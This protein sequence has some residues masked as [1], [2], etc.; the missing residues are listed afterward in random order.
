MTANGFVGWVCSLL[1]NHIHLNSIDPLEML[2]NVPECLH[3]QDFCHLC[4][5]VEF[6][7]GNGEVSLSALK[8]TLLVLAALIEEWLRTVLFETEG[9]LVLDLVV[10]HVV[11]TCQEEVV[12]LWK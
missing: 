4:H 5:V 12:M 11:M 9:L 8:E 6:F 10:A 2:E 1:L 7:L 3:F